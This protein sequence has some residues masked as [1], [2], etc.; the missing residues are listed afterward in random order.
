MCAKINV[1]TNTQTDHMRRYV[2]YKHF[3]LVLC[4]LK[5]KFTT[6]TSLGIY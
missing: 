4:S 2:K 1:L 5:E 3:D 6:K